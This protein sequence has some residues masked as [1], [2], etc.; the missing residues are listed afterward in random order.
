MKD[1]KERATAQNTRELVHGLML[2]V[3]LNGVDVT[4]HDGSRGTLEGEAGGTNGYTEV[5]NLAVGDIVHE[6]MNEHR[7]EG[8]TLTTSPLTSSRAAAALPFQIESIP[9]DC[10]NRITGNIGNGFLDVL[11]NESPVSRVLEHGF[12]GDIVGEVRLPQLNNFWTSRSLENLPNWLDPVLQGTI[13][14][15]EIARGPCQDRST[16]TTTSIM[17]HHDH[18]S[19]TQLGN[20]VRQNA[21]GVDVVRDKTVGDVTLSEERSRGRVEDSTFGHTGVAATQEQKAGS[22]TII[23]LLLKQIWIAGVDDRFTEALIPLNEDID[24]GE[25][26]TGLGKGLNFDRFLSQLVVVPTS[27]DHGSTVDRSRDSQESDEQGKESGQHA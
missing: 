17:T 1:I 22:L 27:C 6:S 23:R 26:S 16:N 12:L 25:F 3:V 13:S 19:N 11:L 15:A 7:L 24:F 21:D 18:M 14:V 2:V 8:S 9:M 4:P 5:R 10:H 20:G